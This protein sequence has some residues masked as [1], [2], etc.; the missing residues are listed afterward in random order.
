MAVLAPTALLTSLRLYRKRAAVAAPNAVRAISQK[1]TKI[2][3]AVLNL[4]VAMLPVVMS[5]EKQSRKRKSSR[6]QLPF[7]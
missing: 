1:L 7:E 5:K 3:I 4:I 6:G 2:M